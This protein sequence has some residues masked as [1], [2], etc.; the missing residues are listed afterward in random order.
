MHAP[1]L[2]AAHEFLHSPICKE[3]PLDPLACS[4]LWSDFSF[5]C[6]CTGRGKRLLPLF[7]DILD[8]VICFFEKFLFSIDRDGGR[9]SEN[10]S[11]TFHTGGGQCTPK[12]PV[13]PL[14]CVDTDNF[15]ILRITAKLSVRKTKQGSQL[16]E[17]GHHTMSRSF[18]F[19]GFPRQESPCHHEPEFRETIPQTVCM[20]AEAFTFS[21][22]LV[23]SDSSV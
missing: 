17:S 6:F 21:R 16:F 22:R 1:T 3:I 15:A 8:H 4:R 9:Q 14:C 18:H 19:P 11:R 10:F 2:M 7:L 5:G 23:F 12:T 20:A 13:S